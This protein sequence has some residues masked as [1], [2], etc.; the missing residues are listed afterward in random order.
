MM[1]DDKML[2]SA[3]LPFFKVEWR[4]KGCFNCNT[5]PA[6]G[7]YI[8]QN[9]AGLLGRD[10]V[11]WETENTDPNNPNLETGLPH[12]W[13]WVEEVITDAEINETAICIGCYLDEEA[14]NISRG[15]ASSFVLSPDEAKNMM[16]DYGIKNNEEGDE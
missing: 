9:V 5:T 10:P 13:D 3:V 8:G 6:Y 1:S 16:A 14:P 4:D 12:G 2:T 11:E 7:F 15:I